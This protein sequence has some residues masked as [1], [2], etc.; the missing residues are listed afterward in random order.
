MNEKRQGAGGRGVVRRSKEGIKKELKRQN[1]QAA[2][3]DCW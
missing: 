3:S 1:E 2:A